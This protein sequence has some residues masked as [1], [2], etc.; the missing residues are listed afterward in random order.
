MSP[1]IFTIAPCV[2]R[3]RNLCQGR[4]KTL[5]TCIWCL[6]IRK[7]NFGL[8]FIYIIAMFSPL[9]PIYIVYLNTCSY[10]FFF[11][12]NICIWLVRHITPCH[13]TYDDLGFHLQ[14][15]LEAIMV[16]HWICIHSLPTSVPHQVSLFQRSLF[17]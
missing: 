10:M 14:Q 3:A 12:Q 11:G 6:H 5:C 17:I 13:S 15:M 9:S 8:N 1:Y 2:R 16:I 4:M 7:E